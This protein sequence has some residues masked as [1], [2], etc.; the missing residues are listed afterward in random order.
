MDPGE[1]VWGGM[2]R[3]GFAQDVDQWRALVECCNEHSGLQK[4]K[5]VLE[6]A[7]SIIGTIGLNIHAL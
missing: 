7:Q 3:I 6:W 2:D 4:C 5:E 1:L